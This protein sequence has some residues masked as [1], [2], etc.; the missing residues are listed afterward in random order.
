MTLPFER[1]SASPPV[2]HSVEE[3]SSPGTNVTDSP[4]LLEEQHDPTYLSETPSLPSPPP[5]MAPK[6][7]QYLTLDQAI[8]DGSAPEFDP[9]ILR[10][11]L[12]PSTG[13]FP[14]NQNRGSGYLNTP[15]SAPY[16]PY[17]SPGYFP[18]SADPAQKHL[19]SPLYVPTASPKRKHPF[20]EWFERPKWKTLLVHIF[21]CLVTYPLLMIV[22]VIAEN[23]SLFWTRFIVGLGCGLVGAGLS[24]SVLALGKSYIEAASRSILQSTR[25]GL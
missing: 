14:T 18:H 15:G 21:L 25:P 1:N 24:L 3:S 11:G 20:S 5:T 2:V 7:V 22:V 6:N 16:S 10:D 23:R 17:G 9:H 4:I 8:Y 13:G 19:L 12:T